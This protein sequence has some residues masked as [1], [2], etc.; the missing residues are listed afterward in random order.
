M[1]VSIPLNV[2]KELCKLN[3]YEYIVFSSDYFK[4]EYSIFAENVE[5]AEQILK[6][7]SIIDVSKDFD[8][9]YIRLVKAN[10]EIRL[11]DITLET[12][13]RAIKKVEGR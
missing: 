4:L 5:E 2:L 1:S 8:V 6:E 9:D 11:A 10:D 12:V 7:K 13:E 3:Q